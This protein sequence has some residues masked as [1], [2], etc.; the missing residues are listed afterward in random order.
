MTD[1]RNARIEHDLRNFFTP[2]DYD[3]DPAADSD[4]GSE[5]DADTDAG[6]G[7]AGDGSADD[8][9]D[10]EQ[11]KNPELKRLSNE[12]AAHRIRAKKAEEALA[13]ATESVQDLL[14][15]NAFIRAALPLVDDI[16]AAWKLA[17]HSLVK[18]D[19]DGNVSG[20][21]TMITAALRSYP[22][23]ER[24]VDTMPTPLP[25]SG[26]APVNGRRANPNSGN[27]AVLVKKFPA[28]RTR[29]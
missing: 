19:D 13:T 9:S 25:G 4:S 23:L 16:D 10:S 28:L 2:A 21:D 6:E 3:A 7:E 8:T 24:V 17:D 1:T 14:I 5:G 18:V 20:M 29:R 26:G 27:A 12:A 22:Y 11:I 15:E